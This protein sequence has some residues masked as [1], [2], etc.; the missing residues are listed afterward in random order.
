LTVRKIEFPLPATTTNIVELM[1][2]NFQIL[3]RGLLGVVTNIVE[4]MHSNFQILL[5][6]L[7]GV[8]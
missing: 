3:L 1:H 2:S 7:L 8:V 5:R 6:G 4:L